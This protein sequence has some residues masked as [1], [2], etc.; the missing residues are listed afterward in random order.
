MVWIANSWEMT[1]TGTQYICWGKLKVCQWT[2]APKFT[3]NQGSIAY[4]SKGTSIH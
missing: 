2:E 1:L 3:V 4:A